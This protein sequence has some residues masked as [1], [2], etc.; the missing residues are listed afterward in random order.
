MICKEFE[1]FKLYW[2]LTPTQWETILTMRMNPWKPVI[3]GAPGIHLCYDAIELY[4]LEII[5]KEFFVSIHG[6]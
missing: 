2:G 6:K 1:E 3:S 4:S 5:T